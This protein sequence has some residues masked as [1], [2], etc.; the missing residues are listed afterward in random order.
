[1]STN[2]EKVREEA[3]QILSD[4]IKIDTTNPPG[5]EMKGA[6]FLQGILEKEGIPG[7]VLESQPGRGNLICNMKGEAVGLA[8]I[9]LL[10]HID[11]VPAEGEKWKVPPLSGLVV[12]GEIWGRGAQDCKS[13]GVMELLALV[14]LKRQGFHSKRDIKYMAAADEETGGKWGVNWLF[15]NHPELMKAEY[16]INE[17]GGVCIAAGERN[18]Y[19]CQTAEKG[20]CWLKVTFRGKSGH[21]SVPQEDNCIVKMAKAIE[22]ISSYHSPLRPTP[23]TRKFIRG[24]AE[25]QN[26]FQSIFIQQLLNPFLSRMAEK[27]ITDSGFKGMAGA[28]LRNTFVPTVV[29]GGQKTNV[30]PSECSCQIDSRLLPGSE[31]E[32][33][34]KELQTLL[35]DVQDYKIEILQ[36]SSPSESPDSD[37]LYGALEK[38]LRR[39]DPKGKLIPAML[40]GA[41]D[42]RYFR[43]KGMKAYGFQPMA[44]T[45]SLAKYLN[46]VHGHDERI[47]I[48]SLIFGTRVLYEVLKDFCS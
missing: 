28:I 27:R 40:S 2:W 42:S 26:F 12:D 33:I 17:G 39:V 14:L 7:Q 11:V 38:A 6:R 1:M 13:L 25:E 37:P 22:K 45:D 21:A 16:V 23:T 5:G 4:Y 3:T 32:T 20:I 43:E 24:V 29:Q 41:T 44:P 19:T 48:E 34:K 30:I 47:S 18:L 10:N 9:I 8:P 35:Y 36:A 15:Q 31:P 46:R